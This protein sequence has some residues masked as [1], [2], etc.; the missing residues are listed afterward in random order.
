[1]KHGKQ[2]NGVQAPCTGCK[3]GNG[4]QELCA[5]HNKKDGKIIENKCVIAN[6]T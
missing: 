1:M 6:A 2:C 3:H 4:K 5:V